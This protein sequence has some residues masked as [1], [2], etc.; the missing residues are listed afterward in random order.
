MLVS[1]VRTG[2][3]KQSW[4]SQTMMNM[5]TLKK[6]VAHLAVSSLYHS[7]ICTYIFPQIV[8]QSLMAGCYGRRQL[9]EGLYLLPVVLFRHLLLLEP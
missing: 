5:T 1:A 3:V 6:K 7:Y 9:K 8:R 4:L 2:L